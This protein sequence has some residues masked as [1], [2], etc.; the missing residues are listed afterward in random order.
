VP[1]FVALLQS[2]KL[3]GYIDAGEAF[4][5]LSVAALKVIAW[6]GV[7]I[8]VIFAASLPFFYH[9]AQ[10]ADAPGLIVMGTILS[11]AAFTVTVFAAVMQRLLRQAIDMKQEND[12]TV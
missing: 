9:W 7:A 11:C 1:F 5:N 8:S 6:C 2:L 3:L 12:L 4:S 10:R